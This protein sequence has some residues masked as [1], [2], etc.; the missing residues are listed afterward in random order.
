MSYLYII[1]QGEGGPV[2]VG[3]SADPEP[4]LRQLQTGNPRR[5]SLVGVWDVYG[6]ERE[7]EAAFLSDEN[8]MREAMSDLPALEGEWLHRCPTDDEYMGNFFAANGFDYRRVR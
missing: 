2:K 6:E 3:I 7:A 5:L 1:A 4:R 8:G